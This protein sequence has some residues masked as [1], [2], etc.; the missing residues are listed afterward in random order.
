MPGK[1]GCS[2]PW[3]IFTQWQVALPLAPSCEVALG[4]RD[5]PIAPVTARRKMLPDLPAVPPGTAQEPQAG[6]PGGHRYAGCW[7]LGNASDKGDRDEM[8]HAGAMSRVSPRKAQAPVGRVGIQCD[9]PPG[10]VWSHGMHWD[11]WAP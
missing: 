2:R 11:T 8:A 4:P 5:P 6:Q 3:S 9:A 1:V 7:G 10:A